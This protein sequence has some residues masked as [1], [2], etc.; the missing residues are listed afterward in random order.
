MSSD[1]GAC[2][3]KVGR[4]A[5]A[6]GLDDVDGEL[7][8]L[9]RGEGG[10]SYSLRDLKEY[11]NR[12]VL[13]A[14]LRAANVEVLDG[15]LENTYRLLTDDD[16][17]AGMRT[18]AIGRLER[19]GVDV[20]GVQRDFV[21]HQSIHTHLRECLDVEKN[22]EPA[23]RVASTRNTVG[24]LE[25]RTEKIAANNLE[26]LAG[27]EVALDGFDVI[28]TTHVTC[29]ECGRRHEFGDLLEAGGCD[30]RLD[31]AE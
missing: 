8:S 30:C 20:E 24:S 27:E 16:V 29:D 28:V 31:S 7:A 26:R 2:D 9:W 25:T 12:R 5:D 22:P 23:D 3:C 17:S 21:S 14:A 6:Y 4:V 10:E 1:E 13:E 19:D 15:E 18:Q 11:F